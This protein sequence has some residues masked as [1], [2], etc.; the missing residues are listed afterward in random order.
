MARLNY[1]I[2]NTDTLVDG[3]GNITHEWREAF[4]TLFAARAVV[5]DIDIT[6]P[7]PETE[8][9]A[10][11]DTA[12]LDVTVTINEQTPDG[13]LSVND[14]NVPTAAELGEFIVEV[15]AFTVDVVADLTMLRSRITDI[16]AD[17]NAIEIPDQTTA[18]IESLQGSG[19]MER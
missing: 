5:P 16:I 10:A 19:Q 12:A 2:P 13:S 17:L 15:E 4:Q 11:L 7:A 18:M 3:D 14:G 1:R 8:A 6:Q 9:P